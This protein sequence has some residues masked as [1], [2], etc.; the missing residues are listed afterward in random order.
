MA[1]FQERLNRDFLKNSLVIA[2]AQYRNSSFYGK[3]EMDS[4]SNWDGYLFPN[5][6]LA[7]FPA[8]N[9]NAEDFASQAICS[10]QFYSN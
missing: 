5:S 6:S 4:F 10:E 9:T 2:I 7:H 8:R 1:A 3:P